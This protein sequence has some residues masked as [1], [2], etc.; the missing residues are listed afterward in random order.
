MKNKKDILLALVI[1]EICGL[2][3]FFIIKNLATENPAI[4]SLLPFTNYL[5]LV[6]PLLCAFGMFVVGL[7]EGV[8]PSLYQVAKF[9]LVG[10]TNFLIDMGVLN[11]LIF[12]SGVSFGM[13]QSAFKGVSFTVAVVN[14]YFWNK[15]WV[16]KRNRTETAGKEFMQFVV[17]S[18]VGFLINIG[19]DKVLV[20]GIGPMGNIQ[21]KTWAQIAAAG[22]AIIALFWNFA[23]Y[24]FIV[25]DSKEVKATQDGQP[26]AL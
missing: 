15:F 23:G 12:I 22:S 26:S 6:F 16:F 19:I 1:G 17:V 21:A 13:T 10:G 7:I 14:S 24:K 3:M 11:I 4:A 20:D 18:I 25:F 2:L 5:P 9:V 8:M